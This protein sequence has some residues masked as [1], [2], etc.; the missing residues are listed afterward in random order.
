MIE[1]KI[2]DVEKLKTELSLLKKEGKSIVFTNGCFDILHVGHVSY[3]EEAKR[4]GDVLVVAINSD[5]SVE[6][7]K[8]TGRPILSEGDRSKILAALESVDFVTIFGQDDPASIVT[9]LDP[10][11]IV[12]GSDWKEEEIIGAKHVKNSGGRVVSIPFLK[13]YST[14]DLINK[15][16]GLK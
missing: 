3:L 6:R 4:Q 13:G 8:G 12:K 14:T 9:E 15:N 16:K 1:D 11:V 5:I 7:L 2:K 10:D